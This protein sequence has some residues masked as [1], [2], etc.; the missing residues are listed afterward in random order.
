MMYM[1][2][3]VKATQHTSKEEREREVLFGLVSLYLQQGRAVG[4]NTLKENGFDHFSSATIRNY[5]VR[6]EK[7]GY[8]LQHH[9]SG[10]RI[11]TD[12]AIREYA[13][14]AQKHPEAPSKDD[15]RYISGALLGETQKFST[16]F[17]DAVDAL[18]ELT[19]CAAVITSPRFD[20]DAVTGVKLVPI[21]DQRVLAILITDFQFI[22]TEPLSLPQKMSTFSLKRIEEYFDA[23]LTGSERPHLTFAEEQFASTAYNE[24]ILRHF[25]SN[26]NIYREDI[27][28]GGLSKL[29]HH[30]EFYDPLVLSHTLNVFENPEALHRILQT[31]YNRRSLTTWIGGDLKNFIP[32]PIHSAVVAIPYTIHGKMAGIVAL[33]G[34]MRMP[35][36]KV[37]GVLQTFS[38]LLS[39]NITKSV[40]KFNL[41]YRE[42]TPQAL[43]Y[44]SK[45]LIEKRKHEKSE[46]KQAK[47]SS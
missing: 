42:Y 1:K 45:P 41:T 24:V 5:F 29:L 44:S 33:L 22:H 2:R 19:G 31:C 3:R 30:A 46:R 18:S 15:A 20:Q 47:V 35:Y 21:D 7:Q 37:F 17:Q 9:T 25:V 12:R 16:Y 4:S 39:Q 28:K 10:G 14:R 26:T 27:Y 36:P 13:H 32:P 43:E 8:L 6:L 38:K 40:N 34:P 23:R 11:P